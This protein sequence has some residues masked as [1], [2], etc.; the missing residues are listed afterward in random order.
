MDVINFKKL[1]NQLQKQLK[2]EP[3]NTLL[4]NDLAIALLETNDG[5][6]ALLQFQK[7][8]NIQPT[9][10]SL[11]NLAYFYYTEGEPL[12]G[13]GWRIK[14]NKAIDLLKKTIQMNPSSYFPYNLL[15]KIYT[16]KNDFKQAKK[17]LREAI[18][19]HPTIESLNNLAICYYKTSSL[20]KAADYFRKANAER[21]QDHGSLNPL[22][23]YGICS[24]ELGR[25]EEALTAAK[26]LMK[27]SKK[28]DDVE[29]DQIVEI[30]YEAKNYSD[31]IS[32]YSKLNLVSYTVDR[33]PPYFFAL[34]TLGQLDKVQEILDSLIEY[35][36][37]EIHEALDEND[38]DW[39]PGRKEE[40][41]D[42]LKMDIKFLKHSAEQ[43]GRG[44][45]PSLAFEPHIETGCYLFG[46]K[47]HNN[48]NYD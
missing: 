10:Q 29:E 4:I 28:T 33:L 41:I 6:G 13:G 32:I 8:A 48:P 36:L 7:A 34:K 9:I 23:S 26:E 22:L 37:T 11:N 15:G 18:N 40:Y 25:R 17:T 3:N 14:T 5:T 45:R 24:A 46:C 12:A 31:V 38:E 19:I 1:V 47:R 20:E 44:V 2:L 27:Q 39:E 42:E 16:E 30:F 43:V 21:T 35:I